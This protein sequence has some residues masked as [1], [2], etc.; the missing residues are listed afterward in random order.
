MLCRQR[1]RRTC[2]PRAAPPTRD[3]GVDARYPHDE[4]A[5]H[6]RE[7]PLA[8]S[9]RATWLDGCVSEKSESILAGG[10][11]FE[12][13]EAPEGIGCWTAEL[14]DSAEA[15]S[16]NILTDDG[17]TPDPAAVE[18]A[19]DIV[20][21]FAELMD[22]A[23]AFLREHLHA[24]DYAISADEQVMI[25]ADPA[26][27]TYPE[28]AVWADGTWM[29]RFAESPLQIADPYGVGVLFVGAAPQSIE[30]FTATDEELAES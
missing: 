30:D 21:N 18:V 23:I 4:S 19:G 26:P 16:V 27:F 28:A 29:L 12:R 25:A 5:E 17:S 10:V 20:L 11:T 8:N 13:V 6:R 1:T 15:G 9:Q 2:L 14:G 24:P 7:R 22:V 3:W